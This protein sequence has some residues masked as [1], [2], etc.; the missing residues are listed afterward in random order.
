VDGK[1]RVDSGGVAAASAAPLY[2][3]RAIETLPGGTQNFVNDISDTGY[4]TGNSRKGG[5]GSSLFPY[6]WRSG[7]ATEIGLLPGVNMFGRGFAVNDAGLV[8]G[9]SG[10]GPSKPFSFDGASLVDLGSNPG[11]SGGFGA[12]VNNNGL[13]VGSA[14]NGLAVRGFVTDGTPGGPLTDLPTPA[15]T[16][17]SFGRAWAI[18]ESG[19]IA[20]VARNASNTQ[21]EPAIWT[22]NGLGGYDVSTLISPAPGS[23][24]EALGINELGQVVGRYSDPASGRTRGFFFDGLAAI[25]LGL[26]PTD[27][28]FVHSRALDLNDAGLIVGHVAR[29]DNAPS[30]GGAA[31]LWD[32]S[33]IFDLNTLIPANSGWRLLSAEGVNNLGQIVGFGTLNG[34]TRAFLLDPIPQT[35]EPSSLILWMVGITGAAWLLSASRRRT[36]AGALTL[37]ARCLSRFR[38]CVVALQRQFLPRVAAR[39]SSVSVA[40]LAGSALLSSSASADPIGYR[41]VELRTLGGASSR[42]LGV[43]DLGQSVG[44]ARNA[45]GN[46][47]AVVWDSNGNPTDLGTLGGREAQA[48]AINN[49][50]EITGRASRADGRFRPFYLSAVG[51]PMLELP[52]L[53]GQAASRTDDGT[54]FGINESSVIG[55]HARDAAGQL[56]AFSWSAT[57]GIASAGTPGGSNGRAWDI[58]ESG[59]LAGWGRDAANRIVGYRWTPATGFDLVGELLMGDDTFG[60]GINDD[61]DVVGSATQ[62]GRSRA[63]FWDGTALVDL[64]EAPGFPGAGANHLNNL[65]Q[66]VGL[67]YRFDANNS[68]IDNTATLWDGGIAYNLNDFLSPTSGWY[69]QNAYNINNVGQ[70]VGWGTLNGQT[71]A[72]LLDPIHATPVPEPSSVVLWLL[73]SS[74]TALCLSLPRRRAGLPVETTDSTRN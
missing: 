20:G 47:R 24:G 71:R 19:V 14:S 3:V 27:P 11:G 41:L 59:Q 22:L 37:P 32:D 56:V 7:V 61:A 25:Q 49:R 67:S 68:R 35:P 64:D 46:L 62:T 45:D 39:A 65:D 10:N 16:T 2:N 21:S 26:L 38:R 54:G 69:L 58:N 6:V 57:G 1:C 8:V 50:G 63:W 30:F 34:Q 60:I 13:I 29:F 42:A 70:I 44:E 43:N 9:E 28:L 53:G 15:G 55:G 5:S 40:V 12:D 31:V 48:Y 52:T 72:F 36:L 74:C 17:N 23:F 18:N 51:Q 66:V 73:G 33:Q 4:A